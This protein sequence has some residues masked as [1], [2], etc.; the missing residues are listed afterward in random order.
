MEAGAVAYLAAIAAE[1]RWD[2]LFVT[3]RP[4]AAGETTQVQSQ[5]WL[6]A[7]GFPRPS[8]YVVKGSRGKIAEALQLDAVIDDRPENCLDV[9]VESTAR[10]IL[11]WP[12]S[13]DS[14][15]PGAIRHGV[16][17]VPTITAALD[18]LLEFDRARSGGVGRIDPPAV[19][20]R[21]TPPVELQRPL[22]PSS[23]RSARAPRAAYEAGSGGLPGL[24]RLAKT[25]ALDADVLARF[26]AH[27]RP[28]P[29]PL[30][31]AAQHEL[32]A[33]VARRRQL[34]EMLTAER[35]RLL[36]AHG[37]VKRDVQ[38]HIHFLEQRLKATTTEL[39]TTVQ[40]SPVWRAQDNLLR[41]VPGIGPTT[42]ATLLAELP[43]LGHLSRQQIA[44]LVG[45]APLN[46]DSGTRRG[47]RVTWGGR[48]VVHAPLYMATRVATRCN[49]VIRAFYQRLRAV[50]KPPKVAL[51]AA[52]HKLLTILNAMIKAQRPWQ[53]A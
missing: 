38:T 48:A 47:P 34:V 20:P 45:V 53:P 5:H 33:L 52:M 39:R 12:E 37:R 27:V 8:V 41:S 31:D 40:E 16:T 50:G 23:G 44:A 22:S 10:A 26:A 17:V 28:E 49:P 14:L 25:D 30:P 18:T 36:V 42:S 21:L 29:R 35:N 6:E 4:P 46:R 13:P 51:V 9:V 11:V 1:R 7:H 19:Q 15:P 24:P 43:E 3:T 2:V 32:T